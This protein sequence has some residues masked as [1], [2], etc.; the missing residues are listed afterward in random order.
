[1][2]PCNFS[3]GARPL[4]GVQA[5]SL[6]TV[7]G[8]VCRQVSRTLPAEQQ[9]FRK[10]NPTTMRIPMRSQATQPSQRSSGER[11][12]I[13]IL[14]SD[15]R[16]TAF[17]SAGCLTRYAHAALRRQIAYLRRLGTECPLEQPGSLGIQ[18]TFSR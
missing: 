12:R 2:L 14:R 9:T 5:G 7:A 17:T 3:L 13:V 8:T 15:D 4:S 1:V 16:A 18:P 10:S 11:P 6:H